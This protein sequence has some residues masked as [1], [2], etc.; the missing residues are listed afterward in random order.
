MER[1]Y[2]MMTFEKTIFGFDAINSI[3]PVT[4][5]QLDEDAFAL[6]MPMGDLYNEFR[7]MNVIFSTFEEAKRWAET[8][9][10][11]KMNWSDF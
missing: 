7:I 10:G 3:K 5:R 9:V 2:T 6:D 4:I 1:N 8:K 11:M